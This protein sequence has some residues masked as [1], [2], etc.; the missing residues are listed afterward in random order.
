MLE[1]KEFYFLEFG[2]APIAWIGAPALPALLTI[3][4]EKKDPRRE[5]VI[6]IISRIKDPVAIPA[7]KDALKDPA[8]DPE[9]MRSVN[10]A[11]NRMSASATRGT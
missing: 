6:F 2:E 3:A 1:R 5:H 8:A 4:K 10:T 7:L 11:L 9:L